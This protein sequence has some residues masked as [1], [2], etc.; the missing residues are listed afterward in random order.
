MIEVVHDFLLCDVLNN[1]QWIWISGGLIFALKA[2]NS[3]QLTMN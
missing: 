3:C 1:D 2:P